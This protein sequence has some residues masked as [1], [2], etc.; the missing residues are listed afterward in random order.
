MNVKR[1]EAL[2]LGGLVRHR[3]RPG[4][5]RVLGIAGIRAEIEPWDDLAAG[6]FHASE[7]YT[8]FARV[9]LLSRLRPGREPA[10]AVA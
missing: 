5:W 10:E 7:A 8:V 2:E 9:H 3:E 1:N 6:A 4:V